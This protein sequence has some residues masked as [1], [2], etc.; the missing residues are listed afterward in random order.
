[1]RPRP[2]CPV[3]AQKPRKLRKLQPATKAAQPVIPYNRYMEFIAEN[4]SEQSGA[5]KL[6]RALK[7]KAKEAAMRF[8]IAVMSASYLRR[9]NQ[10][11][12]AADDLELLRA[13]PGRNT[14]LLLSTLSH[15]KSQLRQDLFVLAELDFK[16][17]GFFVEF[18]ATNGVDM[19]NTYLLE[20]D[21]AWK[22]ILAEPA[23]RWHNDLRNNRT[24]DIET[25]CVWRESNSLLAFNEVEV[26][27]FSTITSFNASDGH[28]KARRNGR[29][30]EVTTISLEDLLVKHNAPRV[31]DYLSIDTEGSEYEILSHFDFEK[32][33]FRIITCEHNCTPTREKIFSLLTKN[34]YLR[35]LENLSGFDDWYV[36]A[37]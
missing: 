4:P 36:R 25:N 33:H 19:S 34:G 20:K 22:G 7:N 27:E 35:K 6:I 32:Y 13:F 37:S 11:A 24:C 5:G 16:R 8:N 12:E 21:F 31:I 17:G 14:S 15:S 26:G 3:K 23:R 18:G 1:M 29:V 9:L 30:Y 28:R 2:A 10:R